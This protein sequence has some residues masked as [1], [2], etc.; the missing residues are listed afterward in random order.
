LRRRGL[1][2]SLRHDQ[3]VK[4]AIRKNLRELIAEEVIITSDGTKRIRIPLHY[5]DQYR[6]KYGQPQQGVG[7]G[8]GQPGDVLGQRKGNGA[9]PGT[10]A[11]GEEPGE[12]TYEVEVPLEDLARMML[13]DLALPWLEEKPERSVTSDAIRMDD[14]RH[15]PNPIS[16]MDIRRSALR[17]IK[18]HAIQDKNP[19]LGKW[20][21]EDIY[22]HT[23]NIDE[24]LH[25]NAAIYM[26]MDVSGSM[27][28]D[29]KYIAK[30]FFFWMVRFLQLKYRQV[31]MV[32]IAHDTEAQVVSEE[33]FFRLT[34]GGGTRCSSA[35]E[36]ALAHLE[37]H[38]PAARWNTYVF[39][40]S[41]GDNLPEDSARCEILVEA[42]L[43]QCCMF[44]YGEIQYY[45]AA[46]YGE[47]GQSAWVPSVL[48]RALQGID[49]PRLT[50][51]TIS[52]KEQLYETLRAILDH[53]NHKATI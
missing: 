15:K 11:P 21:K 8:Q 29:K 20:S 7:Q 41:D 30:S 40:F 2:D 4:E 44:G 24:Q 6:F 33:D 10:G 26:L 17:N 52:R 50:T 23:W 27:T 45:R 22:I 5:L 13:E 3:R 34:Q 39:H 25:A 18:R 12:H 35:Y 9:D 49:H 16:R 31:D 42:L 53:K 32:F 28:T 46:F 36:L 48:Q 43:G 51:V 37:Q 47:V 38:H 1:K 14:V 19:H